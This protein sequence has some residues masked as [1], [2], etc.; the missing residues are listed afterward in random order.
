MGQRG[1]GRATK[2]GNH[3]VAGLCD[4]RET[5]VCLAI[6]ADRTPVAVG[7]GIAANVSRWSR[8]HCSKVPAGRPS[9]RGTWSVT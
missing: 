9:T 4:H 3:G 2:P 7:Y 5:C 8:A 1:S 6:G